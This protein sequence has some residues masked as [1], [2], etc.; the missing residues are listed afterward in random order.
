MKITTLII[1]I[2]ITLASGLA[3]STAMAWSP[4]KKAD[5]THVKVRHAKR[6]SMHK[7]YVVGQDKKMVRY[8]PVDITRRQSYRHGV[9]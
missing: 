6:L 4:A 7:H 2:A 8:T 5:R 3:G 1:S 9:L